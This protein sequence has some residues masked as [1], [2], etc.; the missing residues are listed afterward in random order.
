MFQFIQM[1][2]YALL[3]LI[4]SFNFL[5]ACSSTPTPTY[6]NDYEKS[7]KTPKTTS[8]EAA[9]IGAENIDFV[10]LQR[11]LGLER[12]VGDLGYSEKFFDTCQVGYGFSKSH[13][14]R[15]RY[16][17]VIH[18]QLMCRNSDGTVS[19]IV[20]H[21]DLQSIANQSVRWNISDMKGIAVTDSDGFGQIKVLAA[22]SQKRQ[23][24]KL[25]VE[26]DFL[27]MRAEEVSKIVTPQSWCR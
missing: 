15:Q 12:P 3:L 25:A 27:Y 22:Q 11:S 8:S 2:T 18:F 1:K 5:A 4:A 10:A 9:D 20:R 6:R 21:A 19:E 16:F 17:V 26:S 14:C 13:N 23:R 7:E 24:L